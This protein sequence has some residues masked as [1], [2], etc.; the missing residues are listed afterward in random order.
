MKTALNEILPVDDTQSA[1]SPETDLLLD[2][3][4]IARIRGLRVLLVEDNEF[5]Q[6]IAEEILTEQAGLLVTV[7]ANGQNAIDLLETSVF[8]LVLMDVRMPVLDGYQATKKIRSDFKLARLPI[9]AMTADSTEQD[10]A[11]CL[12]A[13]M[14]DYVSKPINPS[15]IF[16]ILAKWAA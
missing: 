16:T 15:E 4:I 11:E 12:S 7:A 10:R 2:Q 6:M 1:S 14:N 3:D 9:I 13:G 5:N 8:D